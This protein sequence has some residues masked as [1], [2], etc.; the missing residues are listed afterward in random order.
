MNVVFFVPL[1]IIALYEI[2]NSSQSWMV[3]WLRASDDVDTQDPFTLNPVIDG[4][5][6]EQGLEITKVTFD[7]LIKRFPD[8]TQVSVFGYSL[9]CP[10]T[11]L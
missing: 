3:N 6:A 9:S 8:I 11:N 7:E 1:S 4:S 2:S 10:L 5:D